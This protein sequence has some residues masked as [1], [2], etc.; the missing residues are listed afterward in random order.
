MIRCKKTVA[1]KKLRKKGCPQGKVVCNKWLEPCKAVH[2]SRLKP[3]SMSD[4]VRKIVEQRILTN[5]A[6]SRAR[7]SVRA[8]KREQARG[9]AERTNVQ[10]EKEAAPS[11]PDDPKSSRGSRRPPDL[12]VVYRNYLERCKAA[13]RTK[14][15]L[16][17]RDSAPQDL[18]YLTEEPGSIVAFTGHSSK[19]HQERKVSAGKFMSDDLSSKL[20]PT[21]ATERAQKM[22]DRSKTIH[23][24]SNRKTDGSEDCNEIGQPGTSKEQCLIDDVFKKPFPVKHKS[25]RCNTAER[26][27]RKEIVKAR[28]GRC[29]AVKKIA[30]TG[31]KFPILKCLHQS[32]VAN[33]RRNVSK[34]MALVTEKGRLQKKKP[35]VRK[36]QLGKTADLLKTLHDIV[37]LICEQVW[38][39]GTC[40][41]TER[42]LLSSGISM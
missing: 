42:A 19:C 34:I 8:A 33:R 10:V 12:L 41:P 6:I 29:Q 5:L 2:P 31:R 37:Q 11:E 25:P 15:K 20:S 35:D 36:R 7:A 4:K 28:N 21:G 17:C 16:F 26:E 3:A 22:K 18:T 38:V 27:V 32:V 1:V 40:H 30:A 24:S 39:V 13:S 14:S 23:K 9:R